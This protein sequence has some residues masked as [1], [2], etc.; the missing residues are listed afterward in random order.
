MVVPSVRS[1][2]ARKTATASAQHTE[3]L[4]ESKDNIAVVEGDL[5]L[6]EI[7]KSLQ[8]SEKTRQHMGRETTTD[9]SHCCSTGES[10][11]KVLQLQM[12]D[13]SVDAGT[14]LPHPDTC[15]HPAN[16]GTG[17]S[18]TILQARMEERRSESREAQ[19]GP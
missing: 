13:S 3:S 18:D 19:E 2:S 4:V 17:E 12:N 11:R 14:T 1:A 10:R 7:L 6:K 8:A 5:E 16:G 9:S 15:I